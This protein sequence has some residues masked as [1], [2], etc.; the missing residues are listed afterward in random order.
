MQYSI[1]EEDVFRESRRWNADYF[2]PSI[3]VS[4]ITSRYR[5]Y[6]LEE[7]VSERKEFLLPGDYPDWTLNYVGLENISQF[8]RL[9]VKFSPQKGREIRS[10]SKVFRDGDVLYGRL[11]P[12]LNKCLVAG[13]YFSE[14]ICSTE[15]FVLMPKPRMIDPEFLGELL[16]SERVR[17]HISSLVSGAALPRIQLPEFLKVEVPVPEIKTQQEVV[18]R[19]KEARWRFECDMQNAQEFPRRIAE[20][21]ARHVYAGEKFDIDN[22]MQYRRERW[23][24][25]LPM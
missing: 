11:R 7:L 1:V 5:L 21:F 18:A 3:E 14:G 4:C 20:A 13:E 23:S 9:L 8:T 19:L 10:R 22:T 25:R 12:G 24:N 17:T 6:R 15:I 16:V 2:V